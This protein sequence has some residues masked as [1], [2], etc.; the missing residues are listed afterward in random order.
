[1]LKYLTFLSLFLIAILSQAQDTLVLKSKNADFIHSIS[2]KTNT[3]ILATSPKGA[4][5]FTEILSKK[6]NKY[7]FEK[8]HNSVWLRFEAENNCMLSFDIQPFEKICDYDFVLFKLD[9][10]NDSL[11]LINNKKNPIRSN[12]ARNNT[13]LFSKTGLSENADSSYVAYGI[14]DSYSKSI[15]VEK[16]EKYVLVIDN[17]YGGGTG[18]SLRF[19]YTDCKQRIENV[20][21]LNV[22]VLNKENLKPIE[23]QLTLVKLSSASLTIDTLFEKTASSLYYPLSKKTNYA[24]IAQSKG[25][26]SRKVE[27]Q[28]D[29]TTN[30]KSIR[31]VLDSVYLGKRLTIENLYFNPGTAEILRKSFPTLRELLQTMKDNPQLNIEI[32]GHVNDP[33]SGSVRN[34]SERNQSLSESRAKAVFDYLAKRGIQK[35]RMTYKGFGNSQMRFPNAITEQEMEENRRVEIEIIAY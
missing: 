7:F 6:G 14:G 18:F 4:G 27:F 35:E 19:S 30:L 12:I 17:V 25:Y 23:A 29:S 1:M 34:A 33:Y 13:S 15:P 3:P 32:Q 8:E 31:I 28:T 20:P 21:Q 10:K 26:F 16:G 22:V 9:D 24:I 5:S 11:K 2:I